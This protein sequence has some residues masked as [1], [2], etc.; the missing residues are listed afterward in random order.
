MM[1]IMKIDTTYL[2]MKKLLTI[3]LSTLLLSAC[4]QPPQPLRGNFSDISPRAYQTKPIKDLNIRWTGFVVDVENTEKHSCLTIRAKVAD[5]VGRPSRR[6]RIDQGR[7]I[8]CKPTFL[9]PAS[10]M[11]KAVTVTG[12]VKR[13]VNKKIGELDYAHPLVDARVIYVW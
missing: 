12:Q 10:F 7:F 13:M 11:R 3:T 9:E 2:T 4:V 6:V 1:I 5:E 8:A